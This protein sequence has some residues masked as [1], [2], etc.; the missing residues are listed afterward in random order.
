LRRDNTRNASKYYVLFRAAGL[1]TLPSHTSFL[2]FCR[3][4]KKQPPNP[5][6]LLMEKRIGT[7]TILVLDRSVAPMVNSVISDNAEI[8]LARQGL[9]FQHRN[10]AV[11]SLIVEGTVNE[12]NTLSGKLGRIDH[13]EVKVAVTKLA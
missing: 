7:I 9:P 10:V 2:Y 13:V 11:I 6:V 1:F 3:L 5:E 4:I 8:V 12:I